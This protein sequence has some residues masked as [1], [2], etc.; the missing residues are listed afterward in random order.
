M[1]DIIDI[2][3]EIQ[4]MTANWRQ[5]GGITMQRSEFTGH[6]RGLRLGASAR[7]TC[8]FEMSPVSDPVKLNRN[9]AF[10]A[11]MF[12]PA[13]GFRIP[14]VV[15]RQAPD[16]VPDTCEV[17][18]DDQLGQELLLKGL[19]ESVTNLFAGQMISV[20]LPNGDEQLITLTQDLIADVT[21]EGTAYL[22]TPL[23]QAPDDEATVR[24]QVPVATMRLEQGQ[25]W[26]VTP[27]PIYRFPTLSAIEFF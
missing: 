10:I 4:F 7:W 21:G 6:T 24:L 9:R 8:E 27:G 3:V 17:D 1:P 22:A 13:S 2:P 11:R 19:Q 15:V 5:N 12:Q 14:A 18:G 20:A 25:G 23:R 16:T 26:D